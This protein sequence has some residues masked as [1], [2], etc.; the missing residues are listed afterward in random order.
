MSS[1]HK[2]H[3]ASHELGHVVPASV[4][5]R[6]FGILVVLTLVTV[7]ISLVD[8]GAMNIVVAMLVASCKALL[9]ALFFMHLKY[10]HPMLW[11]YAVIPLII[12]ALLLGGVFID[13]PFR[14]Y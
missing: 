14:W 10:E 8:M 2:S 4:F 6:V 13:N 12:L 1:S 3:S 5:I 7:A 9:V 11:M